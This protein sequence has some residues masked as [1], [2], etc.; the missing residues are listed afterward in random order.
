MV[1]KK[2]RPPRV[3]K[4]RYMNN[5]VSQGK[6]KEEL[7]VFNMI[8]LEFPHLQV[9]E[10][11]R[12]I[13]SGRELDIWIPSKRLGIE[14]NGLYYHNSN[15]KSDSYHLWKTMQCE[16][17]GIRLI[18]I[19]SDEWEFKK[20]LVIDRIKKSLG[21]YKIID[22]ESLIPVFI[23][24][25][26]AKE[27]FN[28][29]S[30]TQWVKCDK[31][32]ALLKDNMVVSCI[33]YD[34]NNEDIIIN[35]YSDRCKIKIPGAISKFISFISSN[36]KIK[37][38]YLILDRR[39]HSISDIDEKSSIIEAT[40]PRTFFTKDYKSRKLISEFRLTE[41]KLMEN[42]YVKVHDCGLLKIKLTV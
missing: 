33:G 38:I 16:K 21:K 36:Q 32:V 18:Q 11:D 8:K 25:K 24:Q 7:E 10:S 2:Y 26:E 27:F 23:S 3:P 19:F 13:L 39:I 28:S 42:G 6:S 9:F 1:Y 40:P 15:T 41:N 35:M 5:L 22:D 29:N 20:G 4:P 14:F 30:L 17:Q 12:V 37:D 34:L 31:Y